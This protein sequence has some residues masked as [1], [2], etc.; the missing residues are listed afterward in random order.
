MMLLILQS[1]AA[2]AMM[3][4][5]FFIARSNWQ[6]LSH[7]LLSLFTFSVALWGLAI[8]FLVSEINPLLLW[9]RLAFTFGVGFCSFAMLFALV[10]P[11]RTKFTLPARLLIIPSVL[12]GFITLT[13]IAIKEVRV[14]DGNIDGDFGPFMPV[15]TI[16]CLV[17]ISGALI[18]LAWKLWTARGRMRQQL[19]YMLI[20]LS[21]FLVAMVTTNLVL[22]MFFKVFS[23][24]NL[25]PLFALPM[26][27]IMTYAIVRYDLMD[28]RTLLQR[29]LIYVVSLVCIFLVYALS[30]SAFTA[31]LPD[32]TGHWQYTLTGFLTVAMGI[33]AV[34]TLIRFFQKATDSIFFRDKY[35][36]ATAL[37][38]L[39][40]TLNRNLEIDLIVT[41]LRDNLH[42]TL[43][44]DDI[45]FLLFDQGTVYKNDE[46]IKIGTTPRMSNL[47][48]EVG[49][50]KTVMYRSEQS[51]DELF[52][53]YEACLG[54]RVADVLV[55]IR[56]DEKVLA[57]LSLG[58]KMSGE[59]YTAEDKSLLTIFAAEAAMA[60]EKASLFNQVKEYTEELEIKVEERTEEIRELQAQ[61]KQILVEVSHNLQTPLTVVKGELDLLKEQSSDVAV[62]NAFEHALSDISE[63]IYDLLKLSR[64]EQVGKLVESEE[65]DLSFLVDDQAEYLSVLMADKGI[66]FEYSVEKGMNI[67]G[68]KKRLKDIVM[69]LVSNSVKYIGNNKKKISIDLQRAGNTA[70]LRVK[71]TGLGIG[72]KDLSHVFE[73][74]YRVDDV[75]HKAIKGHGLG[76]AISKRMVELHG[77]TIVV[78]SEVGKGTAFTITLPLLEG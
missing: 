71:D 2:A 34:P 43:K 33:F 37:E 28:I 52:A 42:S 13:N 48:S 74:F 24:N 20:G 1:T 5:G 47:R 17:A 16:Y 38:E 29:G 19:G 78:D 44:T 57:L 26:V 30:L 46:V 67:M 45:L 23:Y 18:I 8:V 49:G 32:G 31:V 7:R 60:F 35:D 15:V 51:S 39:T 25:G 3:V 61:Q 10:F 4:L 62:F 11:Y 12:I 50:Q 63:F 65:V 14:V 72:P 56:L 75:G 40:E 77:G 36:Y 59:A 64:L 68:D 21:L 54:D 9:G 22:P 69:N 55:S 76:L 58:P 66:D 41:K 6:S 73:T 70:Q 53:A 27:G